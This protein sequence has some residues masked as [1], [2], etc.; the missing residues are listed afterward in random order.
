M[1]D[2]NMQRIIDAIKSEINCEK[3]GIAKELSNVDTSTENLLKDDPIKRIY[4]KVSILLCDYKRAPYVN[5]NTIYDICHR[6]SDHPDKTKP[7]R[8]IIDDLS[9]CKSEY[10][11]SLALEAFIRVAIEFND[12][13]LFDSLAV[14]ARQLFEEY[15]DG[16][17]L[18]FFLR[19][20]L[21]I[22]RKKMLDKINEGSPPFYLS[23]FINE[24]GKLFCVIHDADFIRLEMKEMDIP[25]KDDFNISIEIAKF[26]KKI[27]QPELSKLSVYKSGVSEDQVLF[28]FYLSYD[29]LLNSDVHEMLDPRYREYDGVKLA[30]QSSLTIASYERA[31]SASVSEENAKQDVD[32]NVLNRWKVNWK[33]INNPGTKIKTIV[34]DNNCDSEKLKEAVD[35]NYCIVFNFTPS[36][37]QIESLVNFGACFLLW[38]CALHSHSELKLIKNKLKFQITDSPVSIHNQF[39][40]VR[41]S[42]ENK[43]RFVIFWDDADRNALAHL[44]NDFFDN[45]DQ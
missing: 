45:L 12:E 39:I 18:A 22:S 31:L 30:H 15:P 9:R 24:H 21:A 43:A 27:I 36:Q 40:K 14:F 3:I 13:E 20:A 6:L 10:A 5:A 1:F 16:N 11:H 37:S 8:E 38:P 4:K 23:F 34:L 17:D 33:K 19:N 41:K 25:G 2:E 42:N 44:Q 26:F 29:Q 35:Q 7:L 32:L 28:R